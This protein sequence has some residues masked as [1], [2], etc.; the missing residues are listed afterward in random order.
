MVS[1]CSYRHLYHHWHHRD[2]SCSSR[3]RWVLY[4]QRWQIFQTFAILQRLG[5]VDASVTM[6]RD[7]V[8]SSWHHVSLWP[9]STG[10]PGV[11]ARRYSPVLHL[12]RHGHS[13]ADHRPVSRLGLDMTR[14]VTAFRTS[15]KLP[16]FLTFL[17]HSTSGEHGLRSA[18]N[19]CHTAIYSITSKTTHLVLRKCAVRQLHNMQVSFGCRISNAASSSSSFILEMALNQKPD[20]KFSFC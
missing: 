13:A 2:M 11:H 7:I 17:Q 6:L 19:K 18:R 15:Q 12:P 9:S 16:Q 4:S 14:H 1:F 10:P 3:R 8:T 5:R 20:L